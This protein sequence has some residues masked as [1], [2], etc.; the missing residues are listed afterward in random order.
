[1]DTKTQTNKRYFS[2][3]TKMYIFVVVIILIV[4]VGVSAIAFTTEAD[5]I[6]R[7]YKQNTAD[8]A[9]N[10]ASMVDGDF[11]AELRA[12][13]ESDEFQKLRE[14]AE[15]EDNEQ[16]IEDYLKEKGLWEQYSRT[17]DMITEYLENM[18]GIKYL[19]IVAHGDKDA[20]YDMYLIDDAENPIYETGYYEEREAEL[21]GMD[22]TKL[23]EPTISHGDWGWLC[24]D[25]KPVYDSKG[26]C[27]CIVGCD[28]GM[29]DVMAERKR[30][31]LLLVVSTLALTSIVLIMAVMFM[32]RTV[33][34][35]LNSMT[36]EM[37]KFT[38][39]A[40]LNY[41]D[42]GVIYL[43]IKNNDEIGEIYHGIQDMQM[44]IIDDLK[45]MLALQE[46][47]LR[48]EIDLKDKNEQID[49]LNI[50]TYKDAL[51]GVGNK[52][53]YIKR[54]DELNKELQESDTD[55]A[56]V[57]A[58]INN[59]KQINDEHGHRSG[60]M[61]IK[62]CSHIICDVFKHSPVFRIGG[63]E[64]AVLLLDEDYK[65]RKELFNRLKKEFDAAYEQEGVSPWEKYSAAA[66]MAEKSSDDN[67]TEFVFKR[68]DKEMYKNKTLF[69]EKHGMDAR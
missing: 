66:G 29:D 31:L 21:L 5:Q 7:Y 69:K 53:A 13:A 62:G 18:K 37:K 40:G 26:N 34:R 24:S 59:L 15:K 36:E 33:V 32:N 30:L 65:N 1:M 25:F 67:T 35:P 23:P 50:E 14:Q 44:S 61:Y 16:L 41:E 27:V 12:V 28:I 46:E 19:Y 64:F 6:D 9:T 60:D 11:L 17:R 42:A 38:P 56:I 49:Q 52:A 45:N 55:Y 2:I 22:I 43:D 20:E 8:N 4:A 58:D 63:D 54:M 48:A 3:K 47:K 68:A 10:F 51:T 57:V 39:S